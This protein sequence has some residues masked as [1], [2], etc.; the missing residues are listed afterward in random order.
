MLDVIEETLDGLV[1]KGAPKD[2][3]LESNLDAYTK[4][5][6]IQ[7]AEANDFEVK[8]SWNKDQMIE[9]I[10]E[11]LRNSVD[12]RLLTFEKDQLTIL[13]EMLDSFTDQVDWDSEVMTA[14]VSQGLLYVSS[15]EETLLFTMPA[16]FEEKL[17]AAMD[18]DEPV[19]NEQLSAV[20]EIKQAAQKAPF[21]RR[22][23]RRQPVQQRIVGEKV[24]R[25]DPCPCGSGK[26]YKK[27]CWSKDQ[28]S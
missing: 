3:T 22:T 19:E 12:E 5:N 7:L 16:E 14:A 18:E 1:L 6:L 21:G 20:E 24:G 17:V 4:P 2:D 28:I 26:K 10:S 27:C 9:V 25:N 8:K 11:G 23:V 15:D 13:R